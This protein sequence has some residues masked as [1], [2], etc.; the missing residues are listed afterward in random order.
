MTM[1][2]VI[3]LYKLII[4]KS[5][6]YMSVEARCHIRGQVA[7][8]ELNDGKY[9]ISVV[10]PE[11]YYGT[12]VAEYEK[13]LLYLKSEEVIRIGNIIEF[14][15]RSEPFPLSGNEGQFNA[16]K[17]YR[18]QDYAYKIMA[19]T[20]SVIDEGV[21]LKEYL[22]QI[23]D[24]IIDIYQS[25]LPE[26]DAAIVSAM[27]FGR[28]SLLA[29]DDKEMY[30]INGIMHLLAVSG[31][32][33]GT[34]SMILL[35]IISKMPV[36]FKTGRLFL[37]ILLVLYGILTGFGVSCIRAVVMFCLKILAQ[38]VG[39]EYDNISALSFAAIITLAINPRSLF[40]CDFILSYLAVIS[41]T[42]IYPYVE[43]MIL[44]DILKDRKNIHG[45]THGYL[46]FMKLMLCDILIKPML[47]SLCITVMTTPAIMYFY[48]EAPMYSVL[49]N[50][51]V[52]P[53]ISIVF[54]M[55]CLC[56]VTGSALPGLTL[57]FAGSIHYIFVFYRAICNWCIDNVYDI[58]LCGFPGLARVIATYILIGGLLAALFLLNKLKKNNV[59]AL[60]KGVWLAA[61]IFTSVCLKQNGSAGLEITFLDVGQGD[62]IV[63]NLP[64][65]KLVCIDG[66]SS[67]VSDVGRYRI[68][69]YL[70]Y[71]GIKH[72]DYWVITHPDSDHCSGVWEI[73]SRQRYN[74]IVIDNIVLP[75]TDICRNEVAAKIAGYSAYSNFI[76][77]NSKMKFSFDEVSL[78]C[79]NPLEDNE[80]NNQNAGSI[81]LDLE[82][83]KFDALFT[84]DIEGEAENE[85]INHVRQ[86]YELLKV[87]HHGS[88]NSTPAELLK[89][90]NPKC[91]VI[92]C[93]KENSYGHPNDET[94]EKLNAIH[95]CILRTDEVRQ[96]SVLCDK[97]GEWQVFTPVQKEHEDGRG[98]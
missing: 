85:L 21:N 44:P 15:G 11:V 71:K 3:F 42:I 35:W 91:S 79:L 14:R 61:F 96:I 52:L 55:A 98:N 86:D 72:V 20:Y 47:V 34:I 89:R 94:L 18:E 73:L 19:D 92:S 8:A 63:I 97:S 76:Y 9:T 59:K 70:S 81:V 36:G 65:G 33:I 30:R 78:Q 95:S 53:C 26:N 77:I 56:A 10:K 62:G 75:D 93:G 41:I 67:D 84:G 27:L 6:D 24:Y 31:T 88:K 38:I 37:F 83:G 45:K 51:I 39:R 4:G 16:Y 7:S 13:L 64:D 90:I 23:S 87:S 2:V 40:H 49:I 1:V 54:M 66:G 58:R 60:H 28:K 29:D 50:L 80:Y 12:A 43:N 57:F 68:E 46:H 17:Y 69:P 22:R 74:G 25:F 82:Y 5:N 32:H 48:Y